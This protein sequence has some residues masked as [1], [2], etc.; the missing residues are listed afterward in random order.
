MD[1]KYIST[2]GLKQEVM[3][4]RYFFLQVRKSPF[5]GSI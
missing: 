4:D 1:R 5:V 3:A 2:V